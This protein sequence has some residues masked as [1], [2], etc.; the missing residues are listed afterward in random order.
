[1]YDSEENI[2]AEAILNAYRPTDIESF[3]REN[4]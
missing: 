2:A 3:K 1:M 4:L